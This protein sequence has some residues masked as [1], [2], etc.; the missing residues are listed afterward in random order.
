MTRW[1]DIRVGDIVQGKDNMAWEVIDRQSGVF[2]LKRKGKLP[3]VGS[4]TGDVVRLLS[5][6]AVEERAIATAQVRLGGVIEAVKGE[7]GIYQVPVEYAEIGAL[8]AHIYI[9]HG[10]G[11]EGDYLPELVKTHADLHHPDVKARGWVAHYHNPEFL[12]VVQRD[13]ERTS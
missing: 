1:S 10:Q 2:T 9:L 13:A 6:R 8:K 4:P 11:A 5:A 3:F 12:K 7:G